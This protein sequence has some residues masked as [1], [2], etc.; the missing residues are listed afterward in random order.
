MRPEQ[1]IQS[2]INIEKQQGTINESILNMFK[3]YRQVIEQHDEELSRLTTR[4]I[5][6]EN[7]IGILKKPMVESV[8]K[9]PFDI[10]VKYEVVDKNIVVTK[11]N[12]KRTR[13]ILR[14]INYEDERFNEG[15][16]VTIT[17]T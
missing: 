17:F 13:L 10:G 3:T 8:K 12:E 4:L 16:V 2:V 7:I 5:E 6:L 9:V 1:I 15:D 14:S 11:F